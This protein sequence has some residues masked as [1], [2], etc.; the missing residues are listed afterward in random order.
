[1]EDEDDAL[2]VAPGGVAEELFEVEPLRARHHD[3]D[4]VFIRSPFDR[5]RDGRCESCTRG[6]V[7]R[8]SADH[9]LCPASSAANGVSRKLVP[10]AVAGLTLRLHLARVGVLHEPRHVAVAGVALE[11]RPVALHGASV[12]LIRVV[13]QQ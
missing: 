5:S 7:K 8:S 9:T 11:Q 6:G 10:C 12:K 2:V 3:A 4:V 1:M 13:V